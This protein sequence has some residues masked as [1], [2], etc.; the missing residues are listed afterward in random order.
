MKDTKSANLVLNTSQISTTAST[1]E[2]S[3]TI[4]GW[5]NARQTFYFNVNMRQLM[6]DIWDKYDTF[7]LRLNRVNWVPEA[8][9]TNPIYAN[10]N[11]GGLNWRNASYRQESK[12]N[13]YYAPLTFCHLQAS[14]HGEL[15]L[16]SDTMSLVFT[17]GDT[18]PR[19]EFEVRNGIT[20]ALAVPSSNYLP[21]FFF[22]FDIM[23]V[24]N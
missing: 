2:V 19:L 15:V 18:E 9:M 14:A 22:T 21:T 3:N 20:G 23:P 11:I 1:A 13:S 16:P 4:G 24:E 10:I 8:T 7:A 17:K 6:G 5:N 12:A